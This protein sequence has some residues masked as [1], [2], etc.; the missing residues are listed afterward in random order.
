MIED[1]N[2][3]ARRVAE[4]ANRKGFRDDLA[5]PCGVDAMA[6]YTA[7]LHGDIDRAVRLKHAFNETRPQRH[8]GKLA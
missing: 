6:R 8:G 1:L 5:D 2:T 3:W 7:N 4:L